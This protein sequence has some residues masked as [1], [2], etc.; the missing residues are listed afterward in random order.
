MFRA[1]TKNEPVKIES[2][3]GP[4]TEF[5]GNVKS[6]AAIRID[7]RV[8]GDIWAESIVIGEQAVVSGH[9]YAKRI[10]VA[11]RIEGN[12]RGEEQIELLS[13]AQIT[14][15]ITTPKLGIMD[16]AKF[17]GSCHMLKTSA[18]TAASTGDGS[19]QVVS[20]H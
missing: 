11:G 19:L 8:R 5:E 16:G 12:I 17:E 6:T 3:I 2:L 15:D 18:E 20:N 7:G 1:N 9:L 4:G 13:S 14:G 10:T